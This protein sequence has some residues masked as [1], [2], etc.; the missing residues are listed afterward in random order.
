MSE[1]LFSNNAIDTVVRGENIS[2]D[3]NLGT[4]NYTNGSNENTNN[5][6]L[7]FDTSSEVRKQFSSNE[8]SQ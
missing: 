2:D 8:W 3:I 7:C 5:N 1:F 6:Q 4:T